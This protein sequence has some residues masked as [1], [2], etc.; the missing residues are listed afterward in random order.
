VPA[1]RVAEI[2]REL[3]PVFDVLA[4]AGEEAQRIRRDAAAEAGVRRDR[5]TQQA[6]AILEAA[7]R[8][9][10]VQR[11]EAAAAVLRAGEARIRQLQAAAERDARAIA[12]RAAPRYG[13]LVEQIVGTVRALAIEHGGGAPR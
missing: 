8:E 11:A 13:G 10:E 4:A 2:T 3:Q 12:E 7:R 9:A 5:A 6:S 1:D